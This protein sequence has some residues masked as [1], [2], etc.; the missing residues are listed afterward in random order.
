[1]TMYKLENAPNFLN[2]LGLYDNI[3]A[4]IMY[5]C[6]LNVTHL[7]PKF[8]LYS[9]GLE[10]LFAPLVPRTLSCGMKMLKADYGMRGRLMYR[11]G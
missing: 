8:S 2:A 1:M 10:Y 9:K 6:F 4:F 11:L 5:L 3:L 7:Q